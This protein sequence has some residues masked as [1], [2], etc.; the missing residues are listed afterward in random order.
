MFRPA[1]DPSI[2][3][4]TAGVTYPKFVTKKYKVGET[5]FRDWY[6]ES[7]TAAF[8]DDSPLPW[9]QLGYTYDWHKGARRQGLSEYVV[10]HHALVKVK[11]R[12]SAWQFIQ[13]LK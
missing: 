1:H 7:V 6:E 2:T 4:T 11:S 9:T 10:G 13:N 12:E 8:E 5:N 3:T